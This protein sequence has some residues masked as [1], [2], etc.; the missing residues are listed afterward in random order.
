MDVLIIERDEQMGLVLADT[1]DGEG[2]SFAVAS[3]EEAL[4]LPSDDAPR[5]IVTGLNRGHY[6]DQ[7]GLDMV[8]AMRRKWPQL[9]ALYLA[10]L[11]PA[12]LRDGKLAAGERFL[13][14]PVRLAQMTDTVHELLDSG[15]CGR[16]AISNDAPPRGPKARAR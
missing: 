3:D 13:T 4:N 9:C 15:L 16:P 6:E 8:S 2:I 5:V 10:A 11:W 7:R 14:K 12:H 1:L